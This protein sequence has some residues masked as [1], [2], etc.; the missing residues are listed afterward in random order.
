VRDRHE[1]YRLIEQ[2][3][4]CL[5]IASHAHHHEHRFITH[6]DGWRGPEPH[7]HVI[8]VTVSG[9]WWAGFADNRGIPHATMADGMPNGYSII[10][11][12][13]QQ[14]SLNFKAAGRPADYQMQIHVPEAIP[15]DQV[16]DCDVFVNVFNGS[17]RSTVQLRVGR[18][19]DWVPLQRTVEEDPNY[20]QL[21]KRESAQI[22]IL[23]EHSDGES[24]LPVDL[25]R[26]KASTHLWRGKLPHPL[27]A[28]SHL[29][30]IKTTDMHGQVFS[31]QRLLQV[32]VATPAPAT[33]P[34]EEPVLSN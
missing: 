33:E 11:F 6:R 21:Y 19:G 23:K 18:D 9:S 4:F 8:N 12:D 1:L 7:H 30:Q 14:Y 20:V 3:P 31:A 26:P 2:R 24:R 5:S 17:E 34:S 13:G 32:T 27:A 29:L 25:S 22:K 15:T 16:A 28:G 10:S